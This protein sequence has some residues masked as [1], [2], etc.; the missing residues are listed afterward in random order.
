MK[1]R[2]LVGLIVAVTVVIAGC[3]EDPVISV[4]GVTLDASRLVLGAE[5]V[6][7]LTA[8]V[9][10]ADA[11][12]TT[13]TWA[14]DNE[15]VATVD[16][17]TGTV[18][19]VKAGSAAVTVTT[20]DGGWTATCI[21]SILFPIADGDDWTAA[22][23]AISGTSNGSKGSPKV[24]V[25][26]ITE[27]FDAEGKTFG[28]SSITGEYK[29]VRLTGDNK[30]IALSGKGSLIRT[31]ANQ[32][33]VIDGPT[34]QGVN[35][36]NA[37]LVDIGSGSAVELLAGAIQGN[38]NQGNGGGGALNTGTFSMKSGTVSGNTVSDND[39]SFGG[40]V[41]VNGGIFTMKAGTISGNT[42]NGSDNGGGGV[43][44]SGKDGTF[45]M[46]GGTI[47]GNTANGSYG[48]GGVFVNK[49][50]FT[51]KAGNIIENTATGG[52]GVVAYGGTFTMEGGIISGNEASK[53]GGGV[54]VSGTFT[55]EGGTITENT[56]KGGDGGGVFV[57]T[58]GTFTIKGGT[59]SGNEASSGKKGVYVSD[60][61]TCNENGGTVQDD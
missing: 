59:I 32:T 45:T 56:A 60:G 10:P 5:G 7:T 58:S 50:A 33:F 9:S 19:G 16:A 21:V 6:A 54:I 55:M 46:E 26:R 47:S 29:E 36:N 13:V 51:M 2:V 40:G 44:V 39:S 35:D 22:L 15:D 27:D 37:P 43:F 41:Y 61:G 31:A 48:G 42:A 1:K 38:P 28:S 52:G 17:A 49:G 30:A 57:Y 24:F 53:S 4:T 14:S 23:A 11:P 34:L 18:T 20:A 25:L 3:G 12:D 8:T